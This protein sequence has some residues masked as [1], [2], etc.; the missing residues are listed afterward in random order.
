M[1]I[2]LASDHAGYTYKEEIKAFLKEKGHDIVDVGASSSSS[3]DYPIY[4]KA[5]AEKVANGEAK[6]GVLVCST[7][8]GVMIAANKVR[9]AR[10]GIGYNDEVAA[11]LRKHNNANMIAFGA[12]FMSLDD[13][14]KRIEIFLSTEFEGGRHDRRVKEIE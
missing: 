4:A 2:V 14:K 5:A 1:T 8:E 7:G 3:S 9:G 12:S 13:I 10:A 11:L 6:Y